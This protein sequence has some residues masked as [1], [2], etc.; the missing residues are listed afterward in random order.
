[1]KYE[2]PEVTVFTQEE[3]DEIIDASACGSKTGGCYSSCNGKD[4][5][6]SVSV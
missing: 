3:I 6:F 5:T 4:C 1:M 2:R